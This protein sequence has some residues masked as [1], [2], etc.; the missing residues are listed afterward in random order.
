M[1]PIIRTFVSFIQISR[2]KNVDYE[3]NKK[4][5]TIFL[6]EIKFYRHYPGLSRVNW[7]KKVKN[8]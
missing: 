1:K 4:K 7:I 5:K 8:K 3:N 2:V 6:L